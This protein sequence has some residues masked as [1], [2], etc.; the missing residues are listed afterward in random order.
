MSIEQTTSLKQLLDLKEGI[1][2]QPKRCG[3]RT[4]RWRL[5]DIEN[6]INS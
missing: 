2:P 6:Y 4:V 3:S 1:F 5:S